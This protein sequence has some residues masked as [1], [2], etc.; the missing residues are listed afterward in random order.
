MG[1]SQGQAGAQV[2][3]GSRG[4]WSQSSRLCPLGLAAWFQGGT[5][6][7]SPTGTSDRHPA[8]PASQAAHPPPTPGFLWASRPLGPLPVLPTRGQ[9]T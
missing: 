6:Q 1:T 7:P 4:V 9:L 5:K 8:V 3:P 2:Q